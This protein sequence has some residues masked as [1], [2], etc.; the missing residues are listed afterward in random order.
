MTNLTLRGIICTVAHMFNSRSKHCGAAL[1]IMA[2]PLCAQPIAVP[3]YSFEFQAAPGTYPYVN[4]FVDSWQKNPEPA[5]YAPA[6]GQYGIPWLG[7]A[8]VF[9]DVNPYVN[10]VGTQ[11]GYLLAVPEVALFQDYSTSPTHDFNATFEVGNAYNL[12]VGVFGKPGLALGSILT[13]SLYYRDTLDNRVTVGST[14]ITYNAGTFPDTSPLNL[15]DFSV[16]IPPVQAGDAWAGQYIGIELASTIPIEMTSFGNW[17]FDNVR[18]SV[19]P[20]PASATLLLFGFGGL[21]AVRLRPRR[22]P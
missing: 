4:T 10:H 8:G 13:L 2:L 14:A 5:W 17:D 3:N 19:V 6:F 9:F 20:E 15:I 7:T 11:A 12:T 1:A 21:L 18:L 22:S 16:N